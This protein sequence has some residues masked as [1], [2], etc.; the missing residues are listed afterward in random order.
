MNNKTKYFNL[1][2]LTQRK[3]NLLEQMLALEGVVN[4]PFN[5]SDKPNRPIY[6]DPPA[7]APPMPTPTQPKPPQGQPVP[8][9]GWG[10]PNDGY[11]LPPYS[12]P[13]ASN[14]QAPSTPPPTNLQTY[15]TR[16]FILPSE[17]QLNL[18]TQYTTRP[19]GGEYD[20][21]P[22]NNNPYTKGSKEYWVWERQHG[23][24]NS[25]NPQI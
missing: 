18:P 21:T 2:N 5:I 11:V 9:G 14:I 20:I 17:D 23:Y 7:F 16:N 1:C 19:Y 3:I 13:P 24:P 12:S 15:G 22:L 25:G 4:P 10:Y 6:A 8:N